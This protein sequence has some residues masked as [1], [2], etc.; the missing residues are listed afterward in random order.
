MGY[1]TAIVGFVVNN[2]RDDGEIDWMIQEAKGLLK[3]WEKESHRAGLTRGEFA[4]AIRNYNA[5][6]GV[7]KTLQWVQGNPKV[8]SP[9]C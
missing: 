3:H 5:L 6:R 7:I 8:D 4:E 9:L 1:V 2:M